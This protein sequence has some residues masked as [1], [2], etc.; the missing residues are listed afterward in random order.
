MLKL[1]I[2]LFLY[3]KNLE[4]IN[5]THMQTSP[6]TGIY[7]LSKNAITSLRATFIEASG[8]WKWSFLFSAVL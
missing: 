8:R 3:N 5:Y 6:N 2:F 7:L 4:E 1:H